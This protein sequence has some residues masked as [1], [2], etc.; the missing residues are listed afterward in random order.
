MAV[1]TAF[2]VASIGL[3]LPVIQILILGEQDGAITK[4]ILNIL[5]LPKNANLGI[6]ISGVFA[7]F[8][9]IKNIVLIA[10]IYTVN[11]IVSEKIAV[12]SRKIFDIYLSNPIVFHFHNNSANLL[13]SITTG[14]NRSLETVRLILMMVLDGMLMTGAFLLLIFVEPTATLG[15]AAGLGILGFSF[16]KITSSIF[17][18]WGDASHAFERI[19]IKWIN[20]SFDGIR[21]VKLLQAQSFL[22]RKIETTAQRIAHF[23]CLSMTAVHVPRLLVETIIIIGF[24]SIVLILLSANQKPTDIIP[25]LSLFGMA[26]LRLMPSLNRILTSA[27]SLRLS[28]AYISAVH[29]VFCNASTN[30]QQAPERTSDTPVSFNKDIN[31]KNVTYTYPDAGHAALNGI[32]MTI[33]KGQ[34][35]GFVGPSGA[36]KSTLMDIILGLLEPTSGRFLVDGKE[37]TDGIL[38]WQKNIGFV[39]QQV[40]LMDDTIRR[41]IAFGIEDEDINE[42]RISKAMKLARLED[43]I[44]SLPEGLSAIIGEHGTRLS[45]G[46]RQRIAI[47][48]AL[49]RDPDVL[50]FDEATSALDNVTEQEITRAIE[51]LSGDKTILIVAHRLSTVRKC[52][53]IIF[54][55]EGHIISSGSYDELLANN[56]DFRK[57]AQLGDI[58][59]NQTKSASQ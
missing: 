26:A 31:L 32:N 39:P 9:T 1:M 43:F 21:D 15:A 56:K 52:N 25:T 27:T 7:V 28:A 8:F 19:F 38:G 46:Q 40:F 4:F 10:L 42:A 45:G 13:H 55:S 24:L 22:S 47:A 36:G 35:I 53:R 12:F 18:S 23:Q 11:R 2:E 59:R 57:L 37:A 44:V 58:A 54:M 29:T 3:I 48:R 51:N 41:N 14:V 20:Q 6:W 33:T 50:M 16:Y 30:C 5:P 49:Y 34:S 17:V